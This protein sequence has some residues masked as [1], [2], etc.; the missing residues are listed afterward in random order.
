MDRKVE[1]RLFALLILF[2]LVIVLSLMIYPF[3]IP[4]F[5][6]VTL[7]FL[8][9]PFYHWLMQKTKSTYLS[10]I[11][12]VLAL[13][14]IFLIPISLVGG[15]VVN[16]VISSDINISSFEEYELFIAELIGVEFTLSEVVQDVREAFIENLQEYSSIFVSATTTFLIGLLITLFIFFYTL[17][18]KNTFLQ[19]FKSV[20]P[21]SEKNSNYLIEQSGFAIKALLIGQVLT[22]IV[23]GTLG[24]IA[25]FIVGIQGALFWGVVMI[26]LSLIPIVGAFLVW[27]PAGVFLLLEG[28]IVKGIFMLLWGA[29][30]VSQ[31][32]NII[33][34]KLVNRYFK[35]HPVLIFL[36]VFGGLHLFG[37][38][39][40]IIGPL[41]FAFFMLFFEIYKKEYMHLRT[42]ESK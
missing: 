5:L 39:G 2:L 27:L 34:P 29:L 42:I 41:I 21:F 4:I 8:C 40:L 26:I 31:I 18:H 10:A 9:Y 20:L 13:F 7:A 15:L 24:M 32:D 17:L 35:L 11:L 36:G 14:F 22:A 6:G 33:R 12:S 37:M 23:Q 30:I 16:Q 1:L 19:A 28:E 38:I 25:F 3:I